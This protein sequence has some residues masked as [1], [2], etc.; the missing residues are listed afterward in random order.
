MANLLTKRVKIGYQRTDDWA[1]NPTKK[2]L[3]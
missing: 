1:K 3:G 2:P